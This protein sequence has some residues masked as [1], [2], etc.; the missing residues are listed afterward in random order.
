MICFTT[1]IVLN[2][3]EKLDFETTLKDIEFCKSFKYYLKENDWKLQCFLDI[4]ILNENINSF[5]GKFY[6]VYSNETEFIEFFQI[7]KK[8]QRIFYKKYFK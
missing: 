7:R 2:K 1:G 3:V 4:I 6:D 8:K 5:K